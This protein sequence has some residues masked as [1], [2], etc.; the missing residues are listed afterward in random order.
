M[1][2]ML[3]LTICSFVIT[4]PLATIIIKVGMK[5]AR[6]IKQQLYIIPGINLV[7]QCGAQLKMYILS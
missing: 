5:K 2:T 6:I 7:D 3:K 1:D 4:I